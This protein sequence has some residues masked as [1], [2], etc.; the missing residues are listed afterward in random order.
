MEI[1]RNGDRLRYQR[2]AT[3]THKDNEYLTQDY[4]GPV[5]NAEGNRVD[6]VE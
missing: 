4:I 5:M 2:L 6:G 3:L 1:L